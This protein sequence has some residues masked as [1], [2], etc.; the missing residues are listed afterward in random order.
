MVGRAVAT[1]VW[2][3]AASSM[4]KAMVA[5]RTFIWRRL[6]PGAAGS[7]V[8]TSTAIAR[9]QPL[10]DH[11]RPPIMAWVRSRQRVR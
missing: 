3:R 9:L 11:H 6:R 2:S 4:P 1:M 5:N 7:A 10:G 8:A